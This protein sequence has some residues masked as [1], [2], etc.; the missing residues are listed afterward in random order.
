MY[1]IHGHIKFCNKIYTMDVVILFTC[2]FFYLS[3]QWD[4]SMLDF[5]LKIYTYLCQIRMCR[6]TAWYYSESIFYQ[7]ALFVDM[8]VINGCN[9]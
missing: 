9:L 5:N 8:L 1:T 6:F 3:Y 4:V 2:A 7:C